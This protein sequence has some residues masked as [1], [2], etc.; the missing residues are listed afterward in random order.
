MKH[1]RAFL[2]LFICLIQFSIAAQFFNNSIIKTRPFQDFI[3]F[4][5]NIGFEKPI[6]NKFSIESEFLYRN[7]TW[8]STGSEGDF[9]RFYQS[10]GFRFLVGIRKYFGRTKTAPVGWFLSTQ[11]AFSYSKIY[12]IEKHTSISGL[13]FNTV[14]IEK[15][16]PEIIIGFGKQFILFKNISFEFYF[17]PSLYLTY[18][19]KTEII[20]SKEPSEIGKIESEGYPFGEI[21]RFYFSWTIGYH[22]K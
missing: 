12:D 17:A 14:N 21:G 22:I 16:W 9:G 19:E 2:I 13:Y 6:N 1:T 20:D 18:F 3:A 7:R 15:N 5:P 4:N 11:I 10:N 8:E